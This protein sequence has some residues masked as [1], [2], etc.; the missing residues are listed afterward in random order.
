[1][2]PVRSPWIWRVQQGVGFWQP[3]LQLVCTRT[4]P[5]GRRSVYYNCNN[6]DN[7]YKVLEADRI[8]QGG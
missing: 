2:T 5:L 4:L 1:M 8:A 3:L 7:N 6:N